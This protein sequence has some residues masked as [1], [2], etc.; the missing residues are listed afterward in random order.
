MSEGWKPLVVNAV[1]FLRHVIWNDICF[2]FFKD[3]KKDKKKKKDKIK[4]KQ[5]AE[6]ETRRVTE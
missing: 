1:I 4:V 3:V 5:A 6:E 2:F